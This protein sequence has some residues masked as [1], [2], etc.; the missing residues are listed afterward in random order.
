[1]NPQQLTSDAAASEVAPQVDDTMI[2]PVAT[3]QISIA[4]PPESPM[5]GKVRKIGE[6][7]TASSEPPKRDYECPFRND[8]QF[9]PVA[10]IM[11]GSEKAIFNEFNLFRTMLVKEFDEANKKIKELKEQ[12]DN[13]PAVRLTTSM[14]NTKE[15]LKQLRAELADGKSFDPLI[16]SVVRP[17]IEA[18]AAQIDDSIQ[19]LAEQDAQIAG[20]VAQVAEVNEWRGN[21]MS[22]G[23]NITEEAFENIKYKVKELETSINVGPAVGV[24][25][26]AGSP[27]PGMSSYAGDLV[28]TITTRLANIE[29]K[30]DDNDVNLRLYVTQEIAQHHGKHHSH[31][32]TGQQPPGGLRCGH[33][34][35]DDEC[36]ISKQHCPHV[37]TLMTQ[38][39]N[40]GETIQ[41]FKRRMDETDVRIKA[42]DDKLMVGRQCTIRKAPRR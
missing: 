4:T 6:D 21:V 41:A 3:H 34:S 23:F 17:L 29:G 28:N 37:T 36:V 5:R 7:D 15:D 35:G 22:K 31:G 32:L 27:P 9:I 25:G 39:H 42:I 1:M 18:R 12:V 2:V 33:A 19:K 20:I 11:T 30:V 14:Q 13:S 16:D 26:C 40:A 10:D 24:L 8:N 38:M